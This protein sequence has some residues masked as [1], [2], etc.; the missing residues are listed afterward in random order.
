[1]HRIVF[2]FISIGLAPPLMQADIVDTARTAV[3]DWVQVE[4]TISR[5]SIDWQADKALLVDMIAIANKRVERLQKQ[6]DQ[7][8]SFNSLGQEERRKLIEQGTQID[9]YSQAIEDFLAQV[10]NQIRA[11]KPQLPEPLTKEMAASI[12][13]L[14]DA[15]TA[16]NISLNSR[17]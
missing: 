13:R 5:E 15:D 4:Q 16:L 6:V 14:P 12:K 10:E 17:M 7:Q 1:M 11:L 2:L 8:V 9:T 3:S